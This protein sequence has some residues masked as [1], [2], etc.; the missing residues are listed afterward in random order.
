MG[1]AS[2]AGSNSIAGTDSTVSSDLNSESDITTAISS[3]K[4]QSYG[5]VAQAGEEY[6]DENGSADSEDGDQNQWSGAQGDENSG[7]ADKTKYCSPLVI[8]SVVVLGAVLLCF[9]FWTLSATD[10]TESDTDMVADKD[11]DVL[12]DKDTDVLP[13]VDADSK[14][15]LQDLPAKKKKQVKTL[16]QKTQTKNQEEVKVENDK[17]DQA[18][19]ETQKT[20]IKV[21]EA[22][23]KVEEVKAKAEERKAEAVEEAEEKLVEAVEEA[24]VAERKD[25][26]DFQDKS[27]GKKARFAKQR[28]G[29]KV[30]VCVICCLIFL[31]YWVSDNSCGIKMCNG[32]EQIENSDWNHNAFWTWDPTVDDDGALRTLGQNHTSQT[33][34]TGW[35]NPHRVWCPLLFVLALCGVMFCSLMLV[36]QHFLDQKANDCLGK[37]GLMH[38]KLNGKVSD[39]KINFFV[40]TPMVNFV[41]ALTAIFFSLSVI[42]LLMKLQV[43]GRYVHVNGEFE[44]PPGVTARQAFKNGDFRGEQKFL[45]EG[46]IYAN[47][48]GCIFCI[49]FSILGLIS[50]TVGGALLRATKGKQ[51]RGR[52]VVG[53]GVGAL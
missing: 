37:S 25:E 15:L 23:D 36:K 48:L 18:K 14:E 1:T 4:N 26:G 22:K 50:L 6:D 19:E 41:W 34:Y 45:H 33:A 42:G 2:S 16:I 5:A 44:L 9:L 10:V 3:V 7:W 11:A 8:G 21:R 39:N 12:S 46:S 52:R 30:L 38:E 28:W 24:V 53:N 20:E 13:L 27:H 17:V 35:K 31:G 51:L 40:N 47:R 29:F 32:A 49:I 43:F